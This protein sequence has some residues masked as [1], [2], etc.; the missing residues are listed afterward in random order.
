LFAKLS[1]FDL[2]FTVKRKETFINKICSFLR[3]VS[4]SC[5]TLRCGYDIIR[6]IAV[7]RSECNKAWSG[8]D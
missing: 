2:L 3:T 5:Q 1:I 6:I 4:T 8:Q 7:A